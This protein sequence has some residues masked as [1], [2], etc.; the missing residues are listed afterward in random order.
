MRRKINQLTNTN[1]LIIVYHYSLVSQYCK[2][3]LEME[4]RETSDNIISEPYFGSNYHTPDRARLS[5]ESNNDYGMWVSSNTS[6]YDTSLVQVGSG[7]FFV[8]EGQVLKFLAK[9]AA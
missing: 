7:N 5:N 3:P 9:V 1:K 2:Q 6:K 4:S 8:N